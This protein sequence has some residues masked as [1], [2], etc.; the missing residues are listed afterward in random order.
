MKEFNDKVAVITGAA[1]GIGM[2]LARLCAK[3]GMKIVLADIDTKRLPRVERRMKREG[4]TVLAVETDVSRREDI[5]KLAKI[6][7]DTYGEVHLLVNNAAV[8]NTKYTWNYTLKDWEWQL[9]VD[10]LSVIHGIRIFVPIMFKQDNDCHIVNVSSIEGLIKGSG[11]G[12]AIYGLSKHAIVSLTETLS[13]E[14]EA[15]GAKLKVSVVC[16]GWVSTRIVYGDIHRPDK[17]QNP[18]EE[19]IVDTRNQDIFAKIDFDIEE[20]LKLSP[21]ITPARAAEIILKEVK[22]EKLYI[23]THKDDLMRGQVKERFDEIL[24]AF[25][26]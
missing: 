17:L 7:L 9:G 8:G 16:P 11:P 5:E 14:L 15:I 1:S 4:A 24:K 25:D 18:Q 6:T 2:E 21:A 12:G 10:L 3:E 13:I 26:T 23:L 20:A 22:D 19:Q